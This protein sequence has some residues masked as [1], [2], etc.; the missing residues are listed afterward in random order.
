MFL[1]GIGWVALVAA[2]IFQDFQLV[3]AGMLCWIL[4]NTEKRS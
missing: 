2:V 3:I 4:H 1:Y